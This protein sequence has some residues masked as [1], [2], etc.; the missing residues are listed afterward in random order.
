MLMLS[1]DY[2]NYQTQKTGFQSEWHV[3]LIEQDNNKKLSDIHQL[4]VTQFV[5]ATHWR[6]KSILVPNILQ[7]TW[8]QTGLNSSTISTLK[9]QH[10]PI[11]WTHITAK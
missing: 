11:Q 7:C 8:M 6:D 4:T 1:F 3:Q 9:S 10:L 5:A 2:Q